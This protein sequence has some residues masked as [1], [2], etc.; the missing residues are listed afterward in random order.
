MRLHPAGHYGG[1]PAKQ[2]YD[3]IMYLYRQEKSRQERM[4]KA[5][6]DA[7]WKKINE[8]FAAEA[9]GIAEIGAVKVRFGSPFIRKIVKFEDRFARYVSE[10]ASEQP[11]LM[12]GF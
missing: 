12:E 5:A 4:A 7:D 1:N 2:A 11:S 6:T 8:V 10:R 3:A 9:E